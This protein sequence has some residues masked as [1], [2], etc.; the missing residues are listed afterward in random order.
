MGMAVS[1]DVR[2]D[3]PADPQLIADV[4]DWFHWVDDVFS[5]YKPSSFVS[6]VGAGLLPVEDAPPAV[7]WV[8]SEC[9]WLRSATGGY[10]DAWASGSLDPSGFVK[11]WSVDV[12]SALLL[13]RGA[14]DHA[15]NAG[16][17]IRMRG[18]PEPGRRW[19]VGVAHPHVRDAVC[20]V[21][22]LDEG[23]VATSGTAER[24]AHV[25]NPLTGAAALDLASVTV[26]G[27]SLTLTDVYATTALAMGLDAPAWL[28]GLD[29]Y[30]AVVVDAGGYIWS[31]PGLDAGPN[32]EHL[33]DVEDG[34]A[35]VGGGDRGG[36]RRPVGGV[37]LLPLHS[38]ARA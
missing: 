29:G 30:E 17:D 22:E 38:E 14:L 32:E 11:G 16:G 36:G 18:R 24:G 5:T 21:L 33:A 7:Q 34:H 12:A 6:R 10:F 13:G 9:A 26:V 19:R 15:V 20:A 4:C 27:P 8:L 25:V 37:R 23:A 2:G 28:L 35:G 1:I 3:G 31:T